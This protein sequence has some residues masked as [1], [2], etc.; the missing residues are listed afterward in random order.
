MDT[1]LRYLS[2]V[3]LVRQ[4]LGLL[5]EALILAAL[6]HDIHQ[7][8]WLIQLV[9]VIALDYRPA[10]QWNSYVSESPKRSFCRRSTSFRG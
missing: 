9:I 4:S 5:I 6:V 1:K 7:L 2:Q 10:F 3:F 8:Q